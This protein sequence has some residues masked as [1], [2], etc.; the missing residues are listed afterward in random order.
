MKAR[1]RLGL[2]WI[3]VLAAA[4]LTMANAP[5]AA[6]GTGLIFVSNE[7]SSTITML[8][9]ANKIIDTIAACARPRGMHFNIERTAFF[10]GCADDNTIAAY[11]IKTL[12]LIKRIRNIPH[13]ETF[14][15]T[16]DGKY[17]YTS[18]E[19][20]SEASVVDVAS[21]KIVKSYDTGAEPE[22]V[23]V[24]KDGSLVFVT[25]EAANLVHVIDTVKGE[26]IK[27]ISVGARPRRFAMTPD[28]R[29]LWVSCEVAGI[30]DIIDTQT[31]K[32]IA[33]IS[34]L[35]KGMRR[36]EVTPVDLVITADGSKAYVTLGRA[37][38]VAVVDVKSRAVL[39]YILVGRRPWGLQLTHDEKKLYVANG[40]SDDITVID[41]SN[42]QP[43]V[44]IPVGRIPYGI[45]IDDH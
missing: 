20:D 7:K 13:P 33:H 30:V 42:D 43:I 4:G 44:S 6:R 15:L 26:V 23:R 5:V 27:D 32:P 37:N 38:H 11:D 25:S 41:T 14:D 18:D 45:L 17:L 3:A 2:A 12:K 19:D 40:L 31:L 24:S 36:E 1:D 29:E 8:D 39:D 16:P 35:P 10:V 34:F 28:G 9:A 21:G 22:G